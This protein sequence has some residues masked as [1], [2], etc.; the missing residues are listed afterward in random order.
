LLYSHNC[1]QLI[2]YHLVGKWLAFIYLDLY[3][4]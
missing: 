2:K 1:G 3:I 4:F